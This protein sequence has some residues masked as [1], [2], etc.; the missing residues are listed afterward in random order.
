MSATPLLDVRDLHVHFPL[1]GGLLGPRTVVR[2]VD[3]VSFSVR[4]GS[5]FG[6][7]GESGSGKST[8]A[9]A[10]MRLV[11]HTGGQ[12]LLDAGARRQVQVQ[13]QRRGG[14]AGHRARHA[15]LDGDQIDGGRPGSLR[16][17]QNDHPGGRLGGDTGN[18]SATRRRVA[19]GRQGAL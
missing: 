14:V 4:R 2:A 6:I 9:L 15:G 10:I 1:G 17:G 19:C 12:M 16:H 7:V 13:V 5:T 11:K 3:G 8:T 18:A